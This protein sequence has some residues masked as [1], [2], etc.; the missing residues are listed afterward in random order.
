M[1][2]GLYT[3]LNCSSITV[4]VVINFSV[5]QTNPYAQTEKDQFLILE[6]EN[7]VLL[8]T[9]NHTVFLAIVKS[10]LDIG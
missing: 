3:F 6:D 5:D 9:C 8:N 1:I 10:L 4:G 7:M 2:F